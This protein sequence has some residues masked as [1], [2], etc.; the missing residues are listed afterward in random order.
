MSKRQDFQSSSTFF[1]WFVTVSKTNKNVL[2]SMYKAICNLRSRRRFECQQ[3]KELVNLMHQIVDESEEAAKYLK[4]HSAL[5]L[6]DRAML[7][8][9]ETV[10]LIDK[11]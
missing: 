11:L 3:G 4:L 5:D 7:K 8:L 2:E 6:L 9:D 10:T 1:L